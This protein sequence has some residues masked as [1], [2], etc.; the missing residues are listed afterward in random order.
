MRIVSV[1]LCGL[2]EGSS[3][4]ATQITPTL[5]SISRQYLHDENVARTC[6]ESASCSDGP[7][8]DLADVGALQCYQ[9]SENDSLMRTLVADLDG[10]SEIQSGVRIDDMFF[11]T[12][13]IDLRSGE[14]REVREM[15]TKIKISIII[16]F[17]HVNDRTL[18]LK[19]FEKT[20][21]ANGEKMEM[22]SE[23][24]TDGDSSK[25]IQFTIDT[26]KTKNLL[27]LFVDSLLIA[28]SR[29]ASVFSCP[30]SS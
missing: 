20:V 11:A 6:I 15:K 9:K 3:L 19:N 18:I 21:L 26:E 23:S 22:E 14:C 5:F 1:A 30:C 28:Y 7:S 29:P 8:T 2:S 25:R 24:G 16:N 12:M 17:A 4:A 13:E 10:P 27:S